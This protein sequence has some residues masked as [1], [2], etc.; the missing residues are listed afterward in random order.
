MPGG[1]TITTLA[2]GLEYFKHSKMGLRILKNRVFSVFYREYEHKL[3]REIKGSEIP[4]H[5]AVI[6]DGNRRYAG[7]LGKEKSFGHSMG[8]ETTEK[9][10]EWC[11]EIGVK[12][13]TLYAFSTE[14]F[15]RNDAEVD[16][17]F[18][19]MD[20]KFQK[21]YADPRTHEK[22][23][24]IRVI[25]DKAKLPAF[26]LKS[27]DK[28]EKAT[29]DYNRFYLNVAIA[30][31]GRQEIIQAVKGIV[32]QVNKGKLALEDVS[33]AMISKHLYP[34]GGIA[35]PNVDLII[36]TGGDERVSNFL[37]WQANGNECAAYFCAPFWP[38]FRKIDLLRSIRVY[39]AR[40]A[41]NK[42]KISYRLA[43]IADAFKYRKEL[44]EQ[45]VQP[46]KDS[47]LS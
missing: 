18:N 29:E 43:K 25:G 11:H 5:I 1:S 20:R 21:L 28:I 6:M 41:E 36:R 17:L 32:S 16:G 13:L 30:Y 2:K 12:Q 23:M 38:E 37:P 47:G 31:G 4:S 39:Q 19:L 24:K 45:L 34:S 44:K 35:V 46:Q 8:A 33:E 7:M 22:G 9:V 26:L 27:I 10:I 42:R 15:G 14:N 3:T 40:E